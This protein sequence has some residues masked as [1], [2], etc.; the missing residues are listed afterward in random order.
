M[1]KKNETNKHLLIT[2][3]CGDA[4]ILLK[5]H[6]QIVIT[7]LFREILCLNHRLYTHFLRTECVRGFDQRFLIGAMRTSELE[8]TLHLV[9]KKINFQTS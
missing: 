7:T 3:F 4:D 5:L 6:S 8:C 1:S 9:K 2:G